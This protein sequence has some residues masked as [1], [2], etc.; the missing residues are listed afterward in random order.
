MDYGAG[1]YQGGYQ[2][3]GIGSKSKRRDYEQVSTASGGVAP[4]SFPYSPPPPPPPRHSMQTMEV[5][6]GREYTKEFE[7]G[8]G[9]IL[10]NRGAIYAGIGLLLMIVILAPDKGG[11]GAF[12]DPPQNHTTTSAAATASKP[13]EAHTTT[14]APASSISSAAT[15]AK[16]AAPTTKSTTTL[17]ENKSTLDNAHNHTPNF[18]T[19]CELSTAI[20][21]DAHNFTFLND[22]NICLAEVSFCRK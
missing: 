5:L 13:Y 3:G 22:T 10:K 15:A 21:T 4:P 18:V 19:T 2:S 7:S 20:Q 8:E 1:S 11:S 17:E 6:S 14:M 16:T 12:G 9:P